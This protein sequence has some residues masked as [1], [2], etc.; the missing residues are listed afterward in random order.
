MFSGIRDSGK[1]D[2]INC[3]REG[4]QTM[5]DA[6]AVIKPNETG[7]KL[8]ESI[9]WPVWSPSTQQWPSGILTI[10]LL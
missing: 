3:Q 10:D 4:G 2:L 5:Q 8:L 7:P 1:N 6:L 9:E